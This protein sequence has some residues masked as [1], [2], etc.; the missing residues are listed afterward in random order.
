MGKHAEPFAGHSH[1]HTRTFS[2]GR[3]LRV[4]VCQHSEKN[5]VQV[6]QEKMFSSAQHLDGWWE[7]CP[8]V[9]R[10]YVVSWTLRLCT[11]NQRVG[12]ESAVT[13]E[14]KGCRPKTRISSQFQKTRTVTV[15]CTQGLR[16]SNP[17]MNGSPGFNH[18]EAFRRA[19][20]ETLVEMSSIR[21][22]WQSSKCV[23]G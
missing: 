4:V 1:L 22:I 13:A 19:W 15:R 9:G 21:S 20:Q 5:Q 17:Y 18:T 10:V 11:T 7:D 12:S 8:C 23:V 2:T 16:S 6:I 3:V 14:G